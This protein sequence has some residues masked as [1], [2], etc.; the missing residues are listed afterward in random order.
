MRLPVLLLF[1]LAA[2]TTLASD[3]EER[4]AAFV[5]DYASCFVFIEDQVGAG[6]GFIAMA[7]EKPYVF[8]NQHVVAG[9]PG[10][11]CTLLDRS[12][13]KL[14]AASAVVGH[15]IL[16]FATDSEVKGLEVMTDLE[17]NAAIGDD[18]A[19]LGNPEGARVIKPLL[20]K[21]VGIGPNLVEVSAE[22]V[23]GNSGSPIVHLKTGKVIG[24]ASYVTVRDTDSIISQHEP[25]VRR[26]GYRL[27][28][29][30]EWQ[31]VVWAAYHQEFA[32]I[33]QVRMRSQEIV[34]LI[35]DIAQDAGFVPEHYQSAVL[36]TPLEKY[37]QTT[38]RSG[39]NRQ[40][41]RRAEMDMLA[42]VRTA[43][44][45]DIDQA[46]RTV[47]YD[48]FLRALGQELEARGRF[49]QLFDK[50]LKEQAGR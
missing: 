37:V 27:D 39:I 1:L 40:D 45:S 23:P 33:E 29:V 50:I 20:G 34:A 10:F 15:D 4:A 36:R 28:T 24:I 13:L 8:T 38:S 25:E 32:T 26:F 5:H 21:L 44:Q 35:Q 30:K 11:R 46:C 43:C 47:R 18:I 49:R 2:A 31:P 19:V 16:F 6:S 41:R 42:T 17:Q 7:G 12:P 9:H 3:A 48:Y 14:G 22:F